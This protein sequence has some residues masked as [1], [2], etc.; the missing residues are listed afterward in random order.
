MNVVAL[1]I[2]RGQDVSVRVH[3]EPLLAHAVRGL[4]EAGCVSEAVVTVPTAEVGKAGQIVQAVPGAEH[5]CRVL[6]AAFSRAESIRLAFA[7]T[8][9]E[10]DVILIHEAARAFVPATVFHA[11]TDVV[12]QGAEA[13]LPVLPVTD[14]VKLID[15]AGVIAATED[16]S[17]LRTAQTPFACT[18]R[19]LREACANGIDPLTDLPGTVRTV[20]GH[21]AGIRLATPFDVAVAEALLSEEH[22]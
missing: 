11:V 8:R 20:A 14:T 5:R 19:I 10:P 6:P 16:R 17:G 3:G 1:V 15:S 18:R 9:G 22:A 4:L 7:A 12:L 13:A 21:P 2:A